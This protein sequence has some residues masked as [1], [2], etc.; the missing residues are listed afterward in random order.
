MLEQI[1]K[2]GVVL[3]VQSMNGPHAKQEH[4]T[5]E[6]KRELSPQNMR[7]LLIK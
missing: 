2:N 7:V 1:L 5:N 3:H 6:D 4:K